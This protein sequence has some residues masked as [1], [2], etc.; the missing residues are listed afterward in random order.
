[1]KRI[2]SCGLSIILALTFMLSLTGCSDSNKFVGQWKAEVDITDSFSSA[3]SGEN[4]D[5]L[6]YIK[7]TTLTVGFVFVFNSDGT[8]RI[9][10]DEEAWKETMRTFGQSMAEGLRAYFQDLIVSSGLDMSVDELLES[11][12]VDIDSM[13]DEMVSELENSELFGE[14]SISEGNFKAEKGKLYTSESLNSEIDETE[15][16][17]YTF[18]EDSIIF[19]GA[20]EAEFI[21][22][23]DMDIELFPM[24]LTKIS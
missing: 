7:P 23:E 9:T 13:V 11:T 22:M 2:V 21:D 12:G 20:V 1:M 14:D 16:T 18:E 10:V 5:I 24:T 8:Y 4:E 6:K 19:T 17:S 3:M 15:Y